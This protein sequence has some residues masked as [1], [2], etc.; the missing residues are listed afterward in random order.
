M[1][2]QLPAPIV[3]GG[4][5][6]FWKWPHIY[7]YDVGSGHTAYYRASLIDWPLPTSQISLKSKKHFVDGLWMDGRTQATLLRIRP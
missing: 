2:G 7:I 6:S 4:W 1:R 3:N 5:D